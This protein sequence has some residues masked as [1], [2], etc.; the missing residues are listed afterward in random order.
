MPDGAREC[1]SSSSTSSNCERDTFDV[2]FVSGPIIFQSAGFVCKQ[3]WRLPGVVEKIAGEFIS[4]AAP[5]CRQP[6]STNVTK[7]SAFVAANWSAGAIQASWEVMMPARQT[8]HK[9]VR[10]SDMVQWSKHAVQHH[11]ML[12]QI[13]MC[14]HEQHVCMAPSSGM[15]V[16]WFHG[17]SA[18]LHLCTPMTVTCNCTPEHGRWCHDQHCSIICRARCHRLRSCTSLCWQQP[19][20]ACTDAFLCPSGLHGVWLVTPW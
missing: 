3:Y 10:C 12:A 8:K 19:H 4:A 6:R 7:C 5:C 2:A 14:S 11:S 9:I 16:W 20:L 18:H 1:N 15:H 13:S 17:C